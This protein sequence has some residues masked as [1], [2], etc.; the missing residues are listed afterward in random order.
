M[1]WYAF[2][3]IDCSL[4]FSSKL[5]V[6]AFGNAPQASGLKTLP[7]E[8]HVVLLNFIGAYLQLPGVNSSESIRQYVE[9]ISNQ[10]SR[11]VTATALEDFSPAIVHHILRTCEKDYK[12]LGG[13]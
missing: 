7:A 6:V 11:C 4:I 8:R 1:I 3:S 12:L 10:W 13:K 9:V 2:T 5:R